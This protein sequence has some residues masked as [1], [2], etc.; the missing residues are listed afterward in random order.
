MGDP[1]SAIAKRAAEL[2]DKG[3]RIYEIPEWEDTRRGVYYAE[4]SI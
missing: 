1:Q 4:N 3:F 2:R